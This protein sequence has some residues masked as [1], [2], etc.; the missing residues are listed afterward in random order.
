[1]DRITADTF[2]AFNRQCELDRE[3]RAKTFYERALDTNN[4]V[5]QATYWARRAAALVKPRVF[6]NFFGLRMRRQA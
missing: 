4:T 6:S 1:M 2:A 5:A 3:D